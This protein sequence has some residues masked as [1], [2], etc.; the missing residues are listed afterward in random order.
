MDRKPDLKSK[1][2]GII[3]LN[4][5]SANQQ[6]SLYQKFDSRKPY[7]GLLDPESK[8]STALEQ[9]TSDYKSELNLRVNMLKTEPAGVLGLRARPSSV[10]D[11]PLIQV[12]KA[13]PAGQSN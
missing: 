6:L 5:N 1:P 11:R 2:A 12:A 13:G 9:I 10:V 4:A 8:K 3:G 7:S